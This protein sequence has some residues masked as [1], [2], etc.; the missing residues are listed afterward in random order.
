MCDRSAKPYYITGTGDVGP[1][2]GGEIV[3]IV[4]TPAAATATL[5]LREGGSGGTVI[6]VLQAAASGNSVVSEIP[7]LVYAGQLHATLAGAGASAVVAI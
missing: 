3:G 2:I 7:P 1:A 4:L 6:M 5:T